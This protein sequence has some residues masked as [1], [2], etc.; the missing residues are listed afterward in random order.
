M[1]TLSAFLFL[2]V[3]L[4]FDHAPARD[5]FAMQAL[6]CRGKPGT[7]FTVAQNPSPFNAG[8]IRMRM[9]YIKPTGPIGANDEKLEPGMCGWNP[10]QFTGIPPEPGYVYIDIVPQS[11][12]WSST[13]TRQMDTTA[14]AAVFFADTVSLKRYMQS[15]DHYWQF[16]VDDQTNASFSFGAVKQTVKAPTY[17]TITGAIGAP[18]PP[19]PAA[20]SPPQS[21]SAA[22]PRTPGASTTSA[23][24]QLAKLNFKSLE[25]RG[26]GF[27]VNFTARPNALATVAYSTDRPSSTPNGSYFPGAAVQG[28]G[29]VSRGGFSADVREKRGS[30][31]SNYAGA[32]RLPLTQGV[33]YNFIITVEGGGPREQYVGHFVSLQQDIKAT[34]TSYELT[35]PTPYKGAEDHGMRL[36]TGNAVGSLD[37]CG[38]E[39][40][41][42]VGPKIGIMIWSQPSRVTHLA[43]P[44]PDRWTQ[45]AGKN[46]G[47]GKLLIDASSLSVDHPFRAFRIRSMA[48]D[49]EFEAEGQ[50][51]AKWH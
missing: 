40:C 8:Y 12:K 41:Q 46:T 33:T 30:A 27:V 5:P 44:L 43:T 19:A 13:E 47:L 16:Y 39:D 45:M 35:K 15:A 32:S 50:I 7:A 31:F 4:M 14:N 3:T 10:Y 26:N 21:S 1:K 25:R 48:G 6:V 49:V 24:P 29:A 34:I 42:K 22:K 9:N 23:L 51:E 36:F 18:P 38:D 11:Q 2:P 28:S 17:F 20:A 37:V